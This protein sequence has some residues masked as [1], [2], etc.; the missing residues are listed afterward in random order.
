MGVEPT[1]A[2][3]AQPITDFEDRAHHR[4]RTTPASITRRPP[5]AGRRAIWP[6]ILQHTHV[7]TVAGTGAPVELIHTR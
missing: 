7:T 3:S 1:M 2:C 6:I 4:A 5:P